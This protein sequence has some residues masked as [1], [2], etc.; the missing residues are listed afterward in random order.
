MQINPQHL[1]DI[2]KVWISI[3]ITI[4]FFSLYLLV[5]ELPKILETFEFCKDVQNRDIRSP[6]SIR[7]LKIDFFCRQSLISFL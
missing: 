7:L 3:I 2:E 5:Q 4:Y 1:H 6:Q